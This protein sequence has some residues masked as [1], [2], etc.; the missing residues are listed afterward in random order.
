MRVLVTGHSGYIGSVMAPLLEQASHEVVGLD[1]DLFAACTF[2]E[3]PSEV[4]SIRRM[5][6]MSRPRIWWV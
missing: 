1:F 3:P 6:V 5:C 4:E 2:G